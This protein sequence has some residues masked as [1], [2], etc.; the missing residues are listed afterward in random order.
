MIDLQQFIDTLPAKF[1][2]RT[3]VSFIHQYKFPYKT[4]KVLKALAEHDSLHYLSGQPFTQE[5][6]Q[7]VI[8]LEKKFQKGFSPI[9]E[10]YATLLPQIPSTSSI[11]SDKAFSLGFS[12]DK[13][14]TPNG[15][16]TN[17]LVICCN[18]TIA[19]SSLT[20]NTD[21]SSRSMRSSFFNLE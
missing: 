8:Y 12:S 18:L 16:L 13:Y 7:C 9:A 3:A 2:R 5:G 11:A 1:N 21:S 20:V 10:N 19:A 15:V 6:E 4:E 17:P 14:C